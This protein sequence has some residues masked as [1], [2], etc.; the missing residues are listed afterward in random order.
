MTR[1]KIT[2]A[3]ETAEGETPVSCIVLGKSRHGSITTG[4]SSV[5]SPNVTHYDVTI[6]GYEVEG[7]WYDDARDNVTVT[8]PA[9]HPLATA[10][11]LIAASQDAYRALREVSDRKKKWIGYTAND[12]RD[13]RSQCER[14]YAD[15]KRAVKDNAIA[16]SLV[17]SYS[18]D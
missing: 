15:A 3:V 12:L 14:E 7:R 1:E 5:G 9:T 2:L 6:G 17:P 13:M 11:R 16:Y 18:A 8:V 4:N 10:C